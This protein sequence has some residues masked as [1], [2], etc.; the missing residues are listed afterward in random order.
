MSIIYVIKKKNRT[1]QHA[2]FRIYRGFTYKK[3]YR[4]CEKKQILAISD[5]HI[6][7][8]K[9]YWKIGLYP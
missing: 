6:E 4:D 2:T 3:L 8:G 5:I 1:K 7:M 9:K